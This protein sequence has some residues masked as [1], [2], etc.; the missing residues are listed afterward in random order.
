MHLLTQS[1]QTE[2]P[3]C[4]QVVVQHLFLL[5]FLTISH[6]IDISMAPLLILMGTRYVSFTSTTN[7][8]S[9]DTLHISSSPKSPDSIY[10]PTDPETPLL[11]SGPIAHIQWIRICQY[12]QTLPRINNWG[13]SAGTISYQMN[14]GDDNSDDPQ[15]NNSGGR[16]S[17]ESA[18]TK[19]WCRRE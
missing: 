11:P 18:G 10:E 15:D 4:D 5:L 6:P 17:E 9:L 12:P 19:E 14:I 13:P 3:H 8:T 7:A 16:R 1:L 2:Q